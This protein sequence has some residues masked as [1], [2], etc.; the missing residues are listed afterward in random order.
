VTINY[1]KSAIWADVKKVMKGNGVS[2]LT[3]RKGT[4]HTK[5]KDFNV[6]HIASLDYIRA[7]TKNMSDS[8][9]ITFTVSMG[10]YVYNIYPFRDNLEMTIT[11]ATL[12]SSSS[13]SKPIPSV[14]RYKAIFLIKE[15]QIVTSSQLGGV[16]KAT[17]D[18]TGVIEVK[19]QL[20]NRSAEPL[21]IMTI[22]GT[23]KNVK[24]GDFLPSILY[25][26]AT[27]VMVD[28]K[29]SI[30]G[31]DMVTSSNT[32]VIPHV[33]LKQGTL[34]RKIPFILQND[35]AGVFSADI[36][37]Y[38]QNYKGKML[39]FLYPLYDLT[40]F[41]AAVDKMVI[42]ALPEGIYGGIDN[43]YITDG[44]LL[45][46]L[47]T[48]TKRYSDHGEANLMDH[49]V[50]FR[51]TDASAFM[52]KPIQIDANGPIGNPTNLNSY[53]GAK[54]REDGLDYAP[55]SEKG[56]SSNLMAEYSKISAKMV[57]YVDIVWEHSDF[58]LIYPGMP[59]QYVYLEN[60]KVVRLN[61]VVHHIHAY[62]RSTG[63]ILMPGP[64]LTST[65]I[66]MAMEIAPSP[67][68]N[69]INSTVTIKN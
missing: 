29:P 35:V 1:E 20:Q 57:S 18:L 55:V 12:E 31:I 56:I 17:L 13:K 68:V 22:S 42:Y 58:T 30:D 8:I 46:V 54:Q 52:K 41:S 61:G 4:I 43:T 24:V 7:Y 64:F 39:W 45:S 32:K 47:A 11:T 28:G 60:G 66:R 19:L 14:E 34:L 21:R 10:D 50:G 44:G 63:N 2:S 26:E 51:M 59:C 49:G 23:A 25:N 16:D 37:S 15:N 38:I 33:V 67:S 65:A 6:M 5:F 40:R 48:S 69:N 53:V 27:K 3:K 9:H 36:G 62:I